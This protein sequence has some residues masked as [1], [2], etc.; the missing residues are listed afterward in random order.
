MSQDDIEQLER[1]SKQGDVRAQERLVNKYLKEGNYVQAAKWLHEVEKKIIAR[2]RFF[3]S[4]V[5]KRFGSR[6]KLQQGN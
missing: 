5:R 4:I 2:L 3:G 1:K 6:A